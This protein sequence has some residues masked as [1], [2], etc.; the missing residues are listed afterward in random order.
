MYAAALFYKPTCGFC[1]KVIRYMQDNYI[2]I[3]QKNIRDSSQVRDELIAISGKTQVP[4]LVVD[5]E[6]IHESDE[7][8]EWLAAHWPKT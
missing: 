2:D 4:C 7:I 3:P 6:P 1:R 5:G 8:I